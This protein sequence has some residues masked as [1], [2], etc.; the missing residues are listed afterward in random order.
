VPQ[1]GWCSRRSR[2]CGCLAGSAL[3]WLSCLA[4]EGHT[5]RTGARLALRRNRQ[6]ARTA[7]ELCRDWGRHKFW[8]EGSETTLRRRRPRLASF[9]RA[10]GSDRSL[11]IT[12]MVVAQA[13]TESGP[14]I[15]APGCGGRCE[16][17][18]AEGS[19]GARQLVADDAL[20][21]LPRGSV[22][23]AREDLGWARRFRAAA[24]GGLDGRA[25]Q[26]RRT[27]RAWS[28]FCG[29]AYRTPRSLRL[30]NRPASPRMRWS[31]T[32]MPSRAPAAAS[33]RV[34]ARSSADGSGSPLGWL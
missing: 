32:S 29:S 28:R 21:P 14:G 34:S 8:A 1:H 30:T 2:G 13:S 6:P 22:P 23:Q 4:R 7:E 12:G 3:R 33:R 24:G 31:S 10:A 9:Q 5:A 18:D 25:G 20:A 27:G 16:V 15:Q 17:P 11:P 19:P 26:R